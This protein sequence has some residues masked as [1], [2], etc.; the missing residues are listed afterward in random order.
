MDLQAL[1]TFFGWCAVLNIGFL[2]FSAI[3]IVVFRDFTK[4]THTALMKVDEAALD[5]YYFQ[6]LGNY[7]L[8]TLVFSVVPYIALRLMA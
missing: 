6:Y 4:R 1:T 8:A 3:W 2:M 5:T 7:K